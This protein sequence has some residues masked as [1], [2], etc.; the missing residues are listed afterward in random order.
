M[1]TEGMR[2]QSYKCTKCEATDS[3]KLYEK[4]RTPPVINCWKCKAGQKLE[5]PA[6]MQARVGMFPIV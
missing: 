4:E 2:E 5:V 1:S 3:V 6:M